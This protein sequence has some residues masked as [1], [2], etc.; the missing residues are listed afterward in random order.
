VQSIDGVPAI[1]R[2][3]IAIKGIVQG[4]G[5]RPFVFR[6]AV[7]FGLAGWVCNGPDGVLIEAQ[8][9]GAA[10]EAFA[11]TLQLEAPPL[12]LI[13][14]LERRKIPP[15]NAGGFRIEESRSGDGSTPVAPDCDVCPDCLRELFTPSDRRYRYP[16]INCTNC[17]PRYSI[18]TKTPYDRPNTTMAAF[19]LCPDCAAEYHDPADRRFHAQP[20]ACPVCGPKLMLIDASGRGVAA[21]PLAGVVEALRTGRIV[22][23]KGIGGYHLAVDPGNGEAVR[24]LRRRK[25]RDEKPFALLAE[26]LEIAAAIA[27]VSSAETRFL[28]GVERPIVLLR[29]RAG[30]GIAPEVAPANDYFGV[31]LPS[32]PLHYLLLRG[33]FPTLVMTSANLSEEPLLYRD[34]EAI[35]RLAGIADLYLTHDRKIHA[36]CDDSVIRVFRTHPLLLRRSRGYVPRAIRVPEVRRP[37]LGAGGELKAAICLV[38]GD[39]AYPG[40]H[41]GDLKNSATLSAYAG[42]I[43]ALEEITGIRPEMIACDLHPDYH[44][45]IFA[46]TCD[47]MLRKGVQHHHAHLA[48]CMAENLLEGDV[49]GIILDGAGYGPDGTVWGGE[50]LA[51]GYE[52][53]RRVAHLRQMLLPGGDVAAVEP[54]RMA[55]SVLY[56]LQ[57]EDLFSLPF[58]CL[59]GVTPAER[60]LF[61]QMLAK[62]VHSPVTSSCGRLFDAVGA[63]LGLRNR[64]AYEGQ[65]AIELEGVAE[66]GVPCREYPAAI[67]SGDGVLVLDWLPLLKHLL[68]DVHAGVPTAD[69][70][71]SFHQSLARGAAT[72]CAAVR[73]ESGL[74]RVVLSGGVFQNRLLSE[75]LV[76]LLERD[77]FRV[78]THRLIPPNDGG[79]ALGQAMVAGRS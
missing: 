56:Q 59:E 15:A 76:T 45:S 12:A 40:R 38:Q 21:D 69:I 2:Y 28:T 19:P 50:F 54:F 79:L 23:V 11:D 61:L 26:S 66:R 72:V 63:L 67:S 4:V 77:G 42:S 35:S 10:L 27:H 58:A 48:S 3:R 53:Y 24:E 44:S 7:R 71:A 46:E 1:K 6:L 22:A 20:I 55:I 75:M 17:G 25:R 31:M 52:G 73:G 70:A 36:P 78:Y 33:H 65:A 16:F 34:D 39:Q 30:N 43:E 68:E 60:T 32:T 51:G 18:I 57:G 74:D 13:T 49:I 29:K 47:G 9:D 14:S 5:F 62:G 64:M 37:V 8:G 41:L